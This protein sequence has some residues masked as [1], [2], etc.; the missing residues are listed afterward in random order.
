M[1]LLNR[2]FHAQLGVLSTKQAFLG[3]DHMCCCCCC[4]C[5]ALPP[6]CRQLQGATVGISHS[7]RSVG[8]RPGIARIICSLTWNTL[9]VLSSSAA[10][11]S[12]CAVAN[13]STATCTTSHNEQTHIN[14][15]CAWPLNEA[16]G[17]DK[18]RMV[19][20]GCRHVHAFGQAPNVS[21]RAST[22]SMQA[23]WISRLAPS[24]IK[25]HLIRHGQ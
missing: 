25:P 24:I 3:A 16:I 13:C 23:P 6:L 7:V 22:N 4:L 15:S 11:P 19:A 17:P 21:V 8:A 10:R 20:H 18:D 14:H 2:I 12:C 9:M 5:G 1:P